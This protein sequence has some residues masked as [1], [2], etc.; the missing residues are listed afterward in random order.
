MNTDFEKQFE[1]LLSKYSELLLGEEDPKLQKKVKQWALY[2]HISKSMPALTKHWNE[3]Y[4][5]GKEHM[6]SIISEIKSLNEN[7]RKQK[8]S[9]RPET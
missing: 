5:E 4:P 9:N 6:I 7:Y 3:L 1:A 8:N 2:T